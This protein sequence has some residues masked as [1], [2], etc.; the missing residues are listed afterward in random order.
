MMATLGLK[1]GLGEFGQGLRIWWLRNPELGCCKFQ[2][3]PTVLRIV[4]HQASQA[5]L[6]NGGYP[7]LRS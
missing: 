4:P 2:D 1:K 7:R 5:H 6:E 3:W